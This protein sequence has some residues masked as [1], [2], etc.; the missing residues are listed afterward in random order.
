MLW[1]IFEHYCSRKQD[2]PPPHVPEARRHKKKLLTTE[3]IW[4]LLRDFGLCPELCGRSKLKDLLT[5]MGIIL[6]TEKNATVGKGTSR[7]KTVPK[8]RP[9]ERD[10]GL[11][12]SEVME[13]LLSS[14]V[15][16]SA[17]ASFLRGVRHHY[18]MPLA[19]YSTDIK[20]RMTAYP[21]L[22]SASATSNSQQNSVHL[23]VLSFNG[24]LKARLTH[25]YAYIV[26]IRLRHV[27]S[28]PTVTVANNC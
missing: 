22:T 24:F 17:S 9:F 5:E 19:R 26:L 11:V 14:Q 27:V 21:G 8:S 13:R 7:S 18:A 16:T 12:R 20:E 1:S 10:L 6:N 28:S 23:P 3:D 15:N 4:N 25:F 2:I